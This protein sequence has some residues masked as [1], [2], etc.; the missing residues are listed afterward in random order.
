MNEKESKIPSF[1]HQAILDTFQVQ[2]GSPVTVAS[3]A[4]VKAGDTTF[5]V[6]CISVLGLNSTGYKGSLAIRFPK[7]TFLATLEKMIG[8]KCADI[9]PENADACSELLNIIY[10]AARLNI[11]QQGFDFQPAIPTTVVGKELAMPGATHNAQVLRL[12]CSSELGPFAV[13]LSMKKV[14]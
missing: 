10:A 9:T 13:D 8:E 12:A 3:A 7:E 5:P 11:N 1:I 4:I 2:V 6:D 14:A